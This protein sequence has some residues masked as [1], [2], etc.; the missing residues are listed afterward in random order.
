MGLHPSQIVVGYEEASKK[1]LELISKFESYKVEDVRNVDQVAK[2][3]KATVTAKIPNHGEF[4]S[5]LVAKACINSLPEVA[6]KFDIDN[7]RIVHI[8]GSSSEDST[9]MSGMAVRR[10]V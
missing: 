3:L 7:I 2:A 6:N 5:N 10:N 8:L 4:F 9:F 1:A